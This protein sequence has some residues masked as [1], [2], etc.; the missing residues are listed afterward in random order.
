M[1]KRWGRASGSTEVAAKSA[2]LDRV[3]VLLV[4][5]KLEAAAVARVRRRTVG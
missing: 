2:E 1:G 4:V 5:L 3:P